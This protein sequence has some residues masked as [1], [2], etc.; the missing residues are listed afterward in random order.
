MDIASVLACQQWATIILT[1]LL[2]VIPELAI[3]FSKGSIIRCVS[4]QQDIACIS[5]S[6]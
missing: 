3:A 6:I 4:I 2:A 5:V 1:L